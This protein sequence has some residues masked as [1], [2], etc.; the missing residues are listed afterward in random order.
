MKMVIV[1]VIGLIVVSACG[2]STAEAPRETI[3][4][5]ATIDAGIVEGTKEK[6]EPTA[7]PIPKPTATA[8]PELEPTPTLLGPNPISTSTPTPNPQIS[9]TLTEVSDGIIKATEII[10]EFDNNSTGASIKYANKD[11]SVSGLIEDISTD[12]FTGIP[13]ITI[14]T[15]GYTE[16]YVYCTLANASQAQG[17]MKGTSITVS[18]KFS[19]YDSIWYIKL[20]PCSID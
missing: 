3:D 10:S 16:N 2:G 13:Y 8:T 18:G 4:V 7:T 15:G 17:L 9:A 11:I 19:E 5:Q 1:L 12:I 20:N 6:P 14:G